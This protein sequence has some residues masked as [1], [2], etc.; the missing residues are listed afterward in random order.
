METEAAAIHAAGATVALAVKMAAVDSRGVRNNG[1][2]GLP[3][4]AFEVHVVVH[5]STFFEVTTTAPVI[6]TVVNFL[7]TCWHT[8]C[9]QQRS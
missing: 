8:N 1:R 6:N 3:S 2:F 9:N 5:F 4:I 7:H